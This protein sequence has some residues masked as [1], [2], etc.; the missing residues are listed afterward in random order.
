MPNKEIIDWD[1]VV[2]MH[3]WS[4]K[5]ILSGKTKPPMKKIE[6][7]AKSNLETR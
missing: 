1:A 4:K 7:N 5:R 2:K 3:P 6:R